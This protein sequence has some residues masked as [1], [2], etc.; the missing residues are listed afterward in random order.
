M[1]NFKCPKCGGNNFQFIDKFM[2]G[3]IFE[4]MKGKVY[5]EGVEGE[6]NYVNTECVCRD[7]GHK[8]DTKCLHYVI[9]YHN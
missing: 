6:G 5:Q 2:K 8:W 9:D 1:T 4:V 3:Y 7:C